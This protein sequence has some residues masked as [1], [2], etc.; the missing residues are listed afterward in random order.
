[1][2]KHRFIL[3]AAICLL[4]LMMSLPA[5]SHSGQDRIQHG[6]IS[7]EPYSYSLMKR[8]DNN[9]DRRLE[10]LEKAVSESPDFPPAYFRLSHANLRNLPEGLFT[11]SYYFLEGLKAYGRNWW[12]LLDLS[13][14]VT[15]SLLASFL[16][17]L[18]MT[19]AMRLPKEF[20]LL[21]HD[22]REDK[23]H[24]LLL[25]LFLLTAVFGP[26]IF[27][28][29]V[30]MLLGLYFRKKDRFIVYLVLLL[31]AGAPLLTN[32]L[33]TVY[34]ASN[35]VVRAIV[36]VNENRG[37]RLAL[38][39]LAGKED[40][41]SRFSRG[42]ALER[43]GRYPEAIESYSG[44]LA[45]EREARVYVNLG[46]C[47]QMA[48]NTEKAR[49][50]YEASIGIRPSAAAYFNL[51]KIHREKFDFA[52]GDEMYRQAAKLDPDRISS[53]VRSTEK[54]PAKSALDEELGFSD[55]YAVVWNLKKDFWRLS[56]WTPEPL[57]IAVPVCLLVLYFIYLR[58]GRI[59]AYRC[60]RCSKILCPRCEQGQWGQMCKECYQSL[61]KLEA[62]DPK[63]RVSRLL[64][65]HGYQ[66]KRGALLKMLSFAPPGIAYL[67]AGK[68]TSGILL[69][70]TFLFFVLLAALNPFFRT[71]LSGMSHAWLGPVSITALVLIYIF[72]I[73]RVR[74]KQGEGWL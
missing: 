48:G 47:Y 36:E 53:F 33:N 29:S 30:L 63:E 26:L 67:Y 23:K 72:S 28:A 1:M 58:K 10:L 73:F 43:E 46:N 64:R 42:L 13:G 31:T 41:Y 45:L 56:V 35:P 3:K 55:F 71:G 14:L 54:S 7:N 18:L 39:A 11:W 52:G 51:S 2:K 27:L 19:V 38:E 15:I 62:L 69:L 37:N 60:S 61:V 5:L 57:L 40:F 74:R 65:I 50:M 24:L 70:W 68:I 8:A 49:E 66:V 9:Q 22:I 16:L 25:P 12:W 21:T 20:P 17:V 34:S 32:W 59:R 44:A 6:L 4:L